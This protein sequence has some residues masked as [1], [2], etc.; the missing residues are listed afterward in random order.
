VLALSVV[1]WSLLVTLVFS[2]P[3][4][5]DVDVVSI[6]GEFVG[7]FRNDALDFGWGTFSTKEQERN[8]AIELNQGRATQMGIL[9]LT[10][11]T[12]SSK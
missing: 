12:N 11:Q 5:E 2:T 3:S 10:L 4:Q 7:N 8:H 6:F 1:T 9:G